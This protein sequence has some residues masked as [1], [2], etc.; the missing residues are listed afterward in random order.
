MP[1]HLEIV[2]DIDALEIFEVIDQDDNKAIDE[3]SNISK[4]IK[5]DVASQEYD[6]QS[7][8]VNDDSSILKRYVQLTL[9]EVPFV[10]QSLGQ[11]TSYLND[12]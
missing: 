6:V 10:H 8:N 9:L 2:M 1:Y 12:S 11:A 3:V 7:Q 4:D 5:D